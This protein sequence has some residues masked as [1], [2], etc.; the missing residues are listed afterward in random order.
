MNVP[1]DALF[2]NRIKGL[3]PQNRRAARAP[4]K[5]LF[6][7]HLLTKIQNN[8]TALFLLIPSTKITQMVTLR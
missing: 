5:K 1:H 3:A 8:F 7:Q 4:N 6:K 2:Q